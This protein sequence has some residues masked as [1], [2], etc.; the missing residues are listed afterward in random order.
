MSVHS[1]KPLLHFGSDDTKGFVGLVRHSVRLDGLEGLVVAGRGL[2]ETGAAQPH[3]NYLACEPPKSQQA[4]GQAFLLT[5][6][7]Y[8]EINATRSQNGPRGPFSAGNANFF[9][10]D[11][12]LTSTT[13]IVSNF[14]NT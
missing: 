9:T 6:V 7:R 13:I 4:A 5:S 14:N 3:A 12:W 2:D 11:S 8:P 1:S 10:Y